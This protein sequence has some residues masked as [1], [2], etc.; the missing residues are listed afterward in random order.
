MGLFSSK[1]TYTIQVAGMTC[2]HCEKR[3]AEAAESVAGVKQAT[4]DRERGVVEIVVS[5]K[6]EDPSK[7]VVDA[8]T[9]AGYQATV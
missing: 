5:G 4:A 1:Q 7:Q 8:V 9:E 2:G 3:V 6:H